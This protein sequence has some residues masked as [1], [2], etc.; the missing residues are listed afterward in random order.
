[1]LTPFSVIVS[2]LHALSNI[3]LPDI[4]IR[5][6]ILDGDMDH[7]L[8]LTKLHYPTVLTEN[9]N[10]NFKLKCRKFIELIRRSSETQPSRKQ[11]H[12]RASSRRSSLSIRDRNITTHH[13]ASSSH[14]DVFDGQMELDTDQDNPID[15][16][17]VEEPID[18]TRQT[19][20]MDETL[21]FGQILQSEFKDDPRREVKQALEDTFALIAYPDA[22]ESSLAHLL[23][24][25]G[26]A[27]VA[28]ELNSAILG[29]SLRV[30]PLHC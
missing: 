17:D 22:S 19:T 5:L 20:L 16:M 6:A 29:M 28:E 13:S 24:P 4:G 2:T 26:R 7:A 12:I 27:P 3:D 30:S 15:D 9:E 1:M 8:K 25:K 21:S 23:N 11:K 10:I 18:I 14:N